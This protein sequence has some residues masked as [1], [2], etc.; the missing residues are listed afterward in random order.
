MMTDTLQFDIDLLPPPETFS[1]SRAGRSAF[2]RGLIRMVE[3]LSGQPRLLRLYRHWSACDKLA[4]ES[5]FDAALRLLRVQVQITNPA[6]LRRVPEEGGLLL[7]SNHP[8]G[9]VDGL[10]LGQLA[11][12]LR[13]NGHI[14]THS[15]L[16][17]VREIE[18]HLLPV[19]FS[20]TAEARRLTAE[21]RRRAASL[22]AAGRVVVMFPAGSVATANRPLAGPATD[23][24]WH[25]FVAR[26][27]QLPGVVTVPVHVAGQNSRLFQIASHLS[28][29]LRAALIF[30]ETC[31]RM[32]RPIRLTIGAPV[33]SP[34]LAGLGRDAAAADLRR[35][36]MAL[37]GPGMTHPD[38]AFV[39]PSY[40]RW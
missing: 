17:R 22:L 4:G 39:W 38:E 27:A 16:C 40:I 3:L 28:Y 8:F 20:G 30:R 7:V 10:A 34:D 23:P 5:I 33:H 12:R 13:E 14:L 9:I 11:M 25:P 15:L 18:P 35:R 1:Y 24:A 2:R 29:P 32:G 6:A 31:R 21:T 19:D 37:A 26:L 36:C